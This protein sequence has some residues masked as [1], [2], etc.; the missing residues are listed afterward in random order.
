MSRSQ[1]A[2]GD[3]RRVFFPPTRYS[4]P[5]PGS[6]T[7]TRPLMLSKAVDRFGPKGTVTVVR[8]A[9]CLISNAD[10]GMKVRSHRLPSYREMS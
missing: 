5:S 1:A 3:L 6:R 4:V 2:L 10:K 9:Q 8:N 7:L